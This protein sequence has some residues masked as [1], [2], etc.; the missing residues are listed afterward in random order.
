MSGES[1]A[2]SVHKVLLVQ[3]VLR[4]I[5]V[6]PDL[7]ASEFQVSQAVKAVLVRR[8][9]P[10]RLVPKGVLESL[11]GKGHRVLAVHKVLK[12]PL[13][14][15]GPKVKWAAVSKVRPVHEVS[16][17]FVEKRVPVDQVV[18]LVRTACLFSKC[19][20]KA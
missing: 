18:Y 1:Q 20:A 9:V 11:V 13:A 4:A 5:A 7:L 10:A 12:V 16:V 19:K 15:L 2:R 3:Q 17:V 8:V 6:S 14:A